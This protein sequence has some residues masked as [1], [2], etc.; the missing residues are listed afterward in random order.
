M[1]VTLSDAGVSQATLDDPLSDLRVAFD[2]QFE[3]AMADSLNRPVTSVNVDDVELSRRRLLAARVLQTSVIVD[4]SLEPYGGPNVVPES[5]LMDAMSSSSGSSF[6][7]SSLVSTGTT[8]T[9]GNSVC[10]TGERPSV[11][12]TGCPADCPF[13]VLTC[14]VANGQACNGQGSC[15]AIPAGFSVS[16]A[17][18]GR[19]QCFSGY[20]GDS[21]STCAAAF[22]M[23]TEPA[24]VC[25]RLESQTQIVP[26]S[27]KS[28]VGMI[29]G[30]VVAVLVV[31]GAVAGVLYVRTLK[32]QLHSA[33]KEA[34]DAK[35]AAKD[36]KVAADAAAARAE[37]GLVAAE[38]P[39]WTSPA[40]SFHGKRGFGRSPQ[41]TA[42]EDNFAPRPA[43][44]LY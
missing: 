21:C 11:T 2:T 31:V 26:K 29:V 22:V 4:F 7:V 10:E 30:V 43:R 17:H 37:Q 1:G 44:A 12:N 14:P 5:T 24:G 23:A 39:M 16:S 20:A 33:K 41:A 32:K 27:S 15:V 42:P 40:A 38:N 18:T 36:A 9:C 28:P 3:Q 19:C 13:P 34:K 6:T 25:V 8:T 35:K